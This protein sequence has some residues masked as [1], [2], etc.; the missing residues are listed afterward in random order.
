M[1][2]RDGGGGKEKVRSS[3]GRLFKSRGAVTDTALLENMRWEVTG[4]REWARQDDD[5]VERVGWM[6][7]KE[8]AK[9]SGLGVLQ[10]VLQGRDRPLNWM[11]SLICC[12]TL[13][14]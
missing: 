6:V 13:S 14:T 2:C 10:G 3:D 1:N 5:R 8:F 11:R 4:G 7:E 12:S 9:V